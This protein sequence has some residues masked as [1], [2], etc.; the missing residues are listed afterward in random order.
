MTMYGECV[1]RTTILLI[2]ILYTLQREIHKQRIGP[3]PH[4]QLSR[5]VQ[6]SVFRLSKKK[7]FSKN[8]D[9]RPSLLSETQFLRWKLFRR[10]NN[11]RLISSETCILCTHTVC[12][13]VQS[14]S[15]DRDGKRV[16]FFERGK[17]ECRGSS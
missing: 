4:Q 12:K 1:V 7:I 14:Q 6:Y 5:E 15:D 16:V 11:G 17:G 3:H 10:Y 8:D 9:G 13:G 2:L